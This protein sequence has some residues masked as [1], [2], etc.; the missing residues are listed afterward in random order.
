MFLLQHVMSTVQQAVE[1]V[2]EF[3]MGSTYMKFTTEP[4]LDLLNFTF[5]T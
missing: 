4:R 2:R 3:I 1:L 5:N